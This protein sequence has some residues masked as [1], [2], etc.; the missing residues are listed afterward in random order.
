MSSTVAH[1]H[2]AAV[3]QS[4]P[5]IITLSKITED[6]FVVPA[7]AKLTDAQYASYLAGNLY[8]NVHSAQYPNGEIRA[9]LRRTETDT[10]FTR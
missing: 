7:D 9:Q 5:A 2:D 6:G 10:N 8:V 4:G 1:I 3:G